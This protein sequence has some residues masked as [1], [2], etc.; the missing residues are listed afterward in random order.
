MKISLN[1]IYLYW[2]RYFPIKGALLTG[3]KQIPNA[4]WDFNQACSR[5]EQ[6]KLEQA[7]LKK[8][9]S[10]D[11]SLAWVFRVF[12]WILCVSNICHLV[13]TF[14]EFF[15]YFF[16]VSETTHYPSFEAFLKQLMYMLTVDCCRFNL[17]H[18][19][20]ITNKGWRTLRIDVDWILTVG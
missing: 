19:T 6:F 9:P 3:T 11:V 13:K 5:F 10:L 2:I 1:Y 18:D 15:H 4:Y 7:R 12:L 8:I 14:C 20:L 16:F 17:N